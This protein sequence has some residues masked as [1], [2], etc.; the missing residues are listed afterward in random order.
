MESCTLLEVEELYILFAFIYLTCSRANHIKHNYIGFDIAGKFCIVL[1]YL[2]KWNLD[3]HYT[4]TPR[5]QKYC[6]H[7]NKL[8]RRYIMPP[9]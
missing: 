9:S 7:V 4:A 6:L 2:L 1:Q 5:F 8:F 3:T